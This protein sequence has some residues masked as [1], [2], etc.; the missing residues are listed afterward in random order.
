MR[1]NAFAAMAVVY[2]SACGGDIGGGDGGS[3][4]GGGAQSGPTARIRVLHLSPDAPAVDAYVGSE[5]VLSNLAF[6]K[7]SAYAELPSGRADVSITA[8]GAALSTAVATLPNALLETDRDY[9]AFAFGKLANIQANAIED[10]TQ[11]L[12]TNNVRV[13]I[14][15]AADGVGAVNV[16]QVPAMGAATAIALNLRYGTFAMPVDLPT[17]AFVAGI[18]L[19][20]DKSPDLLFDIP[21]LPRGT[22]VNV[23]A[24]LDSTGAPL[25]LAQLGNST[26]ARLDPKK[27]ELRVL[28]LSPNAPPVKAFIDGEL[29]A[30][31]PEIS[32]G[33]STPYAE[34]S[35][36]SHMLDV[37]ADGTVAGAVLK[38]PSLPL[39]GGKYTAAALGRL[40]TLK[41]VFF[42][43]SGNGLAANNIRVRAIHAA[44]GVGEV[45][46]LS[47]PATG[48]P[49]PVVSN[50][51]FGDVSAPLDLPAGAYT[52]GIDLN[53]DANPELY[54]ELPALPAGT[55]ANVY[56]TQDAMGT[57]FAL[58]QLDGSTVAKINASTS[59]VR[60]VHLSRNAPAVDVYANGG[61]AVNA[62]AYGST[63]AA[64][65]V[66]SGATDFAVT[67]AGAAIG[68]AVLRVPGA[69]LL[70]GKAYTVVAYGDLANITAALLE[71]DAT[72]LNATTDVRLRITHV[73]TTVTRGDVYAVKPSGNTL[74]VPNIGF[75]ETKANLDLASN[76]Y[77]VGFDAEANGT[78]DIAFNLPVLAPGS[79]ANV[80]VATD[81]GGAVYLLVQTT[82]A[83]AIRVN[84]N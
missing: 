54:F 68:S 56:V 77:T 2:L 60:V 42:E 48:S 57:V 39:S 82:G 65:T 11:G 9:T 70:P 44:Q 73:A 19:D 16:Y 33:Q 28:H 52:L 8:T 46:V 26:V 14:V 22:V 29:P 12:A 74:L 59:K 53:N 62:L 47:V 58:A 17:D 78:I 31:F 81:A 15:H 34:F 20:D 30:G 32:F 23:F 27:S 3:G 40:P 37:T 79:F 18:D 1:T 4:A 41:A 10:S 51:K 36:A 71:D 13:R 84:A 25:L 24:V 67:A 75:G 43:N 45:D 61:K 21:S 72:G 55:V 76:S 49:A 38:V 66:P 80:F 35:A 69:R 83:G 64:L 50:V 63:T 5:R 6:L 7:T